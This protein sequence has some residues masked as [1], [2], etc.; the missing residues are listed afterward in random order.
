MLSAPA[1]QGR[2]IILWIV[3]GV[4]AALLSYIAFREYL[5]PAFLIGFS[6][7]FRC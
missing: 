3:L 7:A 6:N 1:S 2:R 5:S 4:L